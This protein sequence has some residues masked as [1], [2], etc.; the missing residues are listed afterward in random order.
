MMNKKIVLFGGTFDPIHKGHI[1]VAQVAARYIDYDEVIFIP[2]R[3]S[4]QKDRSPEASGEDRLKMISLAIKG[5]KGFSVSDCELKRAEPSYTLDTVIQFGKFYGSKTTIYW[6]TGADS[7]DDL[8][9]WYRLGELID[10][11]NVCVMFRAGFQKPSFD[12][13]QSALGTE[14]VEKLQRNVINTPLVDINSTEIR[15]RLAAGEDVS[16]MLAPE[17]LEYICKHRLYTSK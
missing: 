11:C 8:L 14:R 12:G 5:Q 9:N 7:I 1:A 16:A 4:P 10:K 2:A 15:R 17:V 3:R 13:F 6:L